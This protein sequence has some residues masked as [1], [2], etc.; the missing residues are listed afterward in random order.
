MA[1]LLHAGV[2][3]ASGTPRAGSAEKYKPIIARLDKDVQINKTPVV[4][5]AKHELL[6]VIVFHFQRRLCYDR[7][8][9]RAVR[10]TG[11]VHGRA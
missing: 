8:G 6:L 5:V 1:I 4:G 10:I 2:Q 9:E 7:H 3:A 11:A